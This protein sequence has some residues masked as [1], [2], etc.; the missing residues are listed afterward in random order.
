MEDRSPL[1]PST[2]GKELETRSYTSISEGIQLPWP[3]HQP[4]RPVQILREAVASLEHRCC[5]P[6]LAGKYLLSIAC[7][8]ST[9]RVEAEFS[10]FTGLRRSSASLT[11][12]KPAMPSCPPKSSFARPPA[13]QLRDIDVQRASCSAAKWNQP[14]LRSRRCWF[15][16]SAAR[17]AGS[18]CA[19]K[20]KG[21]EAADRLLRLLRKQRARLPLVFQELLYV[22][23]LPRSRS[24]SAVPS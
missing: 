15:S 6:G 21:E 1:T 3:R 13:G 11:G 19:L 14:R 9:R 5:L 18:R 12:R 20:R 22:L 24:R 7:A 16:R 17:R 23:W 8:T 4:A 10:L 2:A